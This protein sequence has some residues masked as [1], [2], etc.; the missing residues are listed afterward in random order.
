MKKWRKIMRNFYQLLGTGHGLDKINGGNIIKYLLNSKDGK[1][2]WEEK[3]VLNHFFSESVEMKE[4]DMK[5][6]NLSQNEC[7]C[8]K[9]S[10]MPISYAEWGEN[11]NVIRFTL[12]MPRIKKRETTDGFYFDTSLDNSVDLY[13]K[14]Y[15]E[16]TYRSLLKTFNPH[17]A[18]LKACL[19]GW[20]NQFR[21]EGVEGFER[22]PTNF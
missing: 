18:A 9:L 12:Y 3:R 8:F 22:K 21:R 14:I 7:D 4:E 20:Y 13:D 10:Q 19:R 16:E 11:W 6:Y 1:F 17:W 2:T 5:K 15:D